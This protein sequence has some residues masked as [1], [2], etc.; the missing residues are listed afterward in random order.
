MVA[1]E[2][3]SALYLKGWE[4]RH[5]DD[6]INLL[7][8]AQASE[9]EEVSDVRV[10]EASV[11]AIVQQSWAKLFAT[12]KHEL[13]EV[14]ADGHYLSVLQSL[15]ITNS[16]VL[17]FNIETATLLGTKRVEIKEASFTVVKKMI[18]FMYTGTVD[19]EFLEQRG[20]DLLKA[21]H[22]YGMDALKSLCESLIVC[23]PDNWIKVLQAAIDTG[24]DVITLK[25]SHS[26][27]LF[28]N[29]RL[30]HKHVVKPI[31]SEGIHPDGGP[32][33]LFGDK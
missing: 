22:V 29:Q 4:Y 1:L 13:V 31:F 16:R 12:G 21:A 2:L 10:H 19:P 7:A 28:M 27:H 33:Q 32:N 3:K 14:W 9:L 23:T 18:E 17:K 25:C 26:I 20:V 15:L 30:D 24:S 8:Q 11:P 6:V 5:W